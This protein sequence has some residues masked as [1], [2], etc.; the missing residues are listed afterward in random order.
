MRLIK[1]YFFTL[2]LLFSFFGLAQETFKNEAE[3]IKYSNKLFEDQ[4]FVE[5]E[6]LMLSFL[7]N[8][9]NTEYNFKYGVCVLFKYADKSKAIP[10]LKKL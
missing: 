1:S 3:K 7:S 5:A 8:K 10:Y 4:K 6:P 9:N 2:F